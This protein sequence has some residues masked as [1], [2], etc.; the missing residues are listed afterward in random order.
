MKVKYRLYEIRTERG[1]SLR[2]LEQL[3]GV[4]K[5]TINRIENQMYNPT[6]YTI[7]LLAD[8][9]NVAPEELFYIEK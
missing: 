7:C 6:V 5:A 8:A 4:S 2:E 3:S 9:L 1:M